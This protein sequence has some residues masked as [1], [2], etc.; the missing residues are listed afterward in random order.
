MEPE[1]KPLPNRVTRTR[2]TQ[3]FSQSLQEGTET[4]REATR[5]VAQPKN[6][7]TEK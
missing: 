7:R 6:K 4:R 5:S 3:K 1:H 2:A